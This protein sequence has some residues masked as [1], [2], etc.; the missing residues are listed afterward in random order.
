MERRAPRASLP[1]PPEESYSDPAAADVRHGAPIDPFRLLMTLWEGRRWIV[2]AVIVGGL[3]GLVVGKLMPRTFKSTVVV[4]YEGA[5]DLPGMQEQGGRSIV[6]A[7]E[8]LYSARVLAA[9][10]ARTAFEAPASVLGHVLEPAPE[11]EAGILRI[12]A[13]APSADRAAFLANMAAEELIKRLQD[14][15]KGRL[16]QARSSIR[17]RLTAQEQELAQSRSAYDHF[18]QSHGIADLTTE[19]EEGISS[20][21]ELRAQR[22]LTESE[23]R[24]LEARV[25]QLRRDLSHAPRMVVS[26]ATSARPDQA[27]LS[28]LEGELAAARSRYSPDHPTVRS[29]ELQVAGLQQRIQSGQST[30]TNTATMAASAQYQ[31]L[32]ASLSAAE[33][34]LAAARERLVGLSDLATRAQSRVVEFSQIEGEAASLLAQVRVHEQVAAEQRQQLARIEDAVRRPD[35]GF[36][37]ILEARPPE[38]SESSKKKYMVVLAVPGFALVVVMIVLLLR[39]LRGLRVRTAK[40][41]AYW[42]RG[43]VIATTT[44]PRELQALDDLIADMDDYAPMAVGRTLIVGI[45]SS[46]AVLAQTIASRLGDDWRSSVVAAAGGVGPRG[47]YTPSSPPMGGMGGPLRTPPPMDDEDLPKKVTLVGYGAP[48]PARSSQPPQRDTFPGHDSPSPEPMKVPPTA[49]VQRSRSPVGRMDLVPVREV[50]SWDG[51]KE[52]QALRRAARLADRVAVVIPSGLCSIMEIASI[53]TRLGRVHG[54]GYILVDLPTEYSRL[55]DR[56]GPVDLFW[57]STRID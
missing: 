15:H 23:I 6:L 4:R 14:M 21:A 47:P 32:Q 49:I 50:E 54:V 44:W 26:T 46:Q 22:D 11:P 12:T 43:P 13:S 45:T 36:R 53:P 17:E 52:G 40:E 38:H 18:R 33:A 25:A 37:V 30:T 5:T 35:P 28:R 2:L 16:D 9:I 8:T 34:E 29:L 27:E 10:K 39:E 31:T 19:Q 57:A 7:L 24:A 3:V 48:S 20:A 1:P 51:P 42:G 41:L 56:A 55:E